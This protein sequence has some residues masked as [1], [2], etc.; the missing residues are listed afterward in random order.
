MFK[1]KSSK[2]KYISDNNEVF[3]LDAMHNNI[4]KKF[5]LTNKD[6]E[7]CKVLLSD[8]EVQSNLIMKNIEAFKN[9]QDNKEHINSLWTSNII[10]R[11]KIIELKNNIKELESYNEI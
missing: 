9:I 2:K 4:I 1:E 11:E 8:F 10:I 3:T 6:K 5:E 7:N